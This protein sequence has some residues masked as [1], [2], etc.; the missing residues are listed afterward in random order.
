VVSHNQREFVM[1]DIP[2]LVEGAAEGAGIGDRFLG[3]VERC[4]ALLHLVDAEGEDPV[5]AWKV[6][7]GELDAYGAGL[8]DKPELLVLSRTDT[9]EP[10]QL[11]KLKKKL[12]KAAGTEPLLVSAMSGEGVDAVI[13]ALFDLIGDAAKAE[14]ESQPGPEASWSPLP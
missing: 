2:G 6:V 12:A 1:A 13:E 5:E 3:H 11:A 9:V 14:A 10:K 8:E 4:R 7:R